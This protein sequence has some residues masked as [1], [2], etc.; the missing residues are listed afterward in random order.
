[1]AMSIAIIW[2]LLDGAVDSFV[3]SVAI[4]NATLAVPVPEAS[5]GTIALI[6]SETHPTAAAFAHAVDTLPV[7]AAIL[8]TT[9][10]V[11]RNS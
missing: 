8:R 7:A 11:A 1:M 9:W 6:T 3:P 5:I 2:A 4:A 10:N